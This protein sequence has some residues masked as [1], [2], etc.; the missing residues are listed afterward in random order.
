MAPVWY[1]PVGTLLILR[2]RPIAEPAG[3]ATTFAGTGGTGRIVHALAE[4]GVDLDGI[5]Q[6]IVDPD[7]TVA[8]LDSL[9][10]S[11][12]YPV[13]VLGSHLINRPEEPVRRALIRLARR[14]LAPR[15]RL[16]VEHHPADWVESAGEVQPTPGGAPGMLE[17]RRDPPFV[18]AVSVYDAGGPEV[19]QPFTA[20]V[21][22]EAELAAELATAGLVIE[23]R[24]GP[25]WVRARSRHD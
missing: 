4:L 13:V 9:D 1:R 10:A 23:Q 18:S 2:R 15:G 24:L 11:V 12:A 3:D 5:E 6:A 21:L 16:L 17:I 22:S 8:A 20:R 19:R 14:H 25:T 7:P